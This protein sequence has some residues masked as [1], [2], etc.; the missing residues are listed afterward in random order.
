MASKLQATEETLRR[1]I[2]SLNLNKE[3]S[4]SNS[5]KRSTPEWPNRESNIVQNDGPRHAFDA[6]L[7]ISHLRCF[8]STKW[9]NR[10]DQFFDF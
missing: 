4:N 3:G 9:L 2:E 8:D 5:V 6:R 7:G 10:V 1:L